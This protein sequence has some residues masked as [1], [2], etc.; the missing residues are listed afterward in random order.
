[1]HGVFVAAGEMAPAGRVGAFLGLQNTAM[2]GAATLAAVLVGALADVAG[3]TATVL[4]LIVPTVVA[5]VLTRP[6]PD[7]MPGPARRDRPG[8]AGA[9]PPP[10]PAPPATTSAPAADRDPGP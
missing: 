1:M 10:S 5:A 2:F 4:V 7:A 3:W 6:V 8:P 9:A